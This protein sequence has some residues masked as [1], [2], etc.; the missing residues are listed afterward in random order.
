MNALKIIVDEIRTTIKQTFDDKE[1]SRAQVAH[2]VIIVGNQLLGKHIFKRDSGAFLV[3][4]IV[5]VQTNGIRKFIEM[6]ADIFD[7]D[8]DGGI[9]LM[10]YY[11]PD[12]KCKPEYRKRKI[13]RTSPSELEWLETGE[14]TKPSPS[15]PYFWR[16]GNIISIEGIES[17]PV[18]KVEVMIYQTINPLEKIDLNKEFT[19]PAELLDTLKRQV[20]DL[21]RY[22]FFFKNDNANDGAD[23]ASN[24]QG[25]SVIPK[26]QSVN[27]QQE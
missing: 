23:T 5:D 25:N 4:Y 27:Q 9:E 6:P 7:F 19:F 10:S 24:P 14:H 8:R 3:P 15:D 26:I 1:V 17:V 11:N 2:W 20:T 18:K 16:A 22:S 12:E 21:A 13:Q